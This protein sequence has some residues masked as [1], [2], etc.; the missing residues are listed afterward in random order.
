MPKISE[1]VR[2]KYSSMKSIEWEQREEILLLCPWFTG[3]LFT[4]IHIALLGDLSI[5]LVIVWIIHQQIS[6]LVPELLVLGLAPCGLLGPCNIGGYGEY[7]C[8]VCLPFAMMICRRR[9]CPRSLVPHQPGP[10]S[11]HLC[12]RPEPNPTQADWGQTR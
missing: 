5:H 6:P 11:K 7:A 8:R 3:F 12:G 2:G 4:T 9:A 10:Q 1:G